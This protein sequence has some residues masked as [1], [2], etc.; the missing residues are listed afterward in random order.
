M[1]RQE[2][3]AYFTLGAAL[4]PLATAASARWMLPAWVGSLPLFGALG[5]V[6]V[7]GN[8][9]AVERLRAIAAAVRD[10]DAR[11]VLERRTG[12]RSRSEIHAA[13]DD[14]LR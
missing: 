9:S 7:V 2:R 13:A 1:R 6:A 8:A 14:R 3:A 10:R 11:R 5:L 12:A 4:V